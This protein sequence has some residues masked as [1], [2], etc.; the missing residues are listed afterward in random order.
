MSRALYLML[1]CVYHCVPSFLVD[2][3]QQPRNINIVNMSQK[4][5]GTF[6]QSKNTIFW[7]RKNCAFRKKKKVEIIF[8][9]CTQIELLLV[10]LAILFD[11]IN[12]D[13]FFL[14][15][16]HFFPVNAPKCHGHWWFFS[17]TLVKDLEKKEK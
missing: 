7:W 14:V 9:V 16:W 5:N 8:N 12:Y 10:C 13:A 15:L 17:G 2:M 11:G 4:F 1:F 6:I 3:Y